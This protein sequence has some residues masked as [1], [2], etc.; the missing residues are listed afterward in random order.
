MATR[1][2][3]W[4]DGTADKVY[5]SYTGEIGN[6]VLTISGDE[7]KTGNRRSRVIALKSLDDIIL[8]TLEVSQPPRSRAFN[9]SYNKSYQ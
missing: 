3:A 9:V 5:I 1:T 2:I 7:N 8:A 4:D 6:S